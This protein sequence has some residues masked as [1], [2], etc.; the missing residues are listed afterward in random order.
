[1][2]RV[3]CPLLC[4][5]P[6]FHLPSIFLLLLILLFS[7]LSITLSF[8]L[9]G[10]LRFIY[11]VCFHFSALFLILTFSLPI[12]F[13]WFNF[14]FLFISPCPFIL[15][16][17]NL[18]C[19]TFYNS[20]SYPVSPHS[21]PLACYYPPSPFLFLFASISQSLP[22]SLL[23]LSPPHPLLSTSSYLISFSLYLP[24]LTPLLSLPHPSFSFFFFSVFLSS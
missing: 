13:F 24:S 7:F 10:L 6:S 9:V 8:F 4:S 3:F 20:L 15:H 22:L 11:F 12:F 18:S 16:Y 17:L 5:F 2:K 21:S 1:M 19:L 14:F 23:S